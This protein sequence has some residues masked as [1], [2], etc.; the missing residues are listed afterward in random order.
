MP[1]DSPLRAGIQLW[2]SV[3][4]S[5]SQ[6]A[7]E[8]V[9]SGTDEISQKLERVICTD[10][11]PLECTGGKRSAQIAKARKT[12]SPLRLI[13]EQAVSPRFEDCLRPRVHHE[14]SIDTF[15]MSVDCMARDSEHL[16][17]LGVAQ[18]FGAE[19]EHL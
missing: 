9:V 11:A 2:G 17:D 7:V 6:L 3:T 1:T 16:G 12:P 19:Y 8:L 18:A 15:E 10:A 14:F 13:I 4:V 5:N